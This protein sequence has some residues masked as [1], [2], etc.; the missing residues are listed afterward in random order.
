MRQRLGDSSSSSSST[1]PEGLK[2]RLLQGI[3]KGRA[4][5]QQ[6]SSSSSSKGSLRTLP[7]I[8]S[9]A[10]V[11]VARQHLLGD[12]PRVRQLRATDVGKL[13]TSC[14]LAGWAPPQL[15]TGEDDGL[16]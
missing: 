5:V 8:G 13:V 15:F 4:A 2:A 11:L 16:A 14:C 3:P 9:A 10:G 12:H 7:A 1:A 6:P